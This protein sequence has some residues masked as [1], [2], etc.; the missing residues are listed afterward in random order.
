MSISREGHTN[1]KQVRFFS[2]NAPY[3]FINPNPLNYTLTWQS[4]TSMCR[5]DTEA[6]NSRIIC[7]KAT[8]KLFHVDIPNLLHARNASIVLVHDL[9]REYTG[10]I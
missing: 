5:T 2:T 1:F 10:K 6:L 7:L 4:Y 3:L 9:Q 8:Y